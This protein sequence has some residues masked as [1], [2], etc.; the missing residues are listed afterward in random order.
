MPI[1]PR[2]NYL[3]TLEFRGPEW[4]PT[5]FNIAPAVWQKYREDME[6]VLLR[7]PLVFGEYDR[8][9]VAFDEF[10]ASYRENE[11]F[12]DEWG[13]VWHNVQE[14]MLGQV[15]GHP[16]ANWDALATY[17]LPDPLVNDNTMFGERNWE[18]I[19]AQVAAQKQRGEPTEGFAGCLFDRLFYL[20][21]FE[22]LMVDIATDAPQLRELTDILTHYELKMVGKWLELGVDVIHF[23][24]D[25][26]GQQA[27]MISPAKFRQHIKPMFK[28][29][30]QTCRAGG[31]HVY[32]S[33]D[34][35]LLEIVDDL[36]ECGV[37]VHDPQLR[38]NTLE[39][40][41]K[42]YKGKMCVKLDLD[43]QMFPFCTPEEIR[44]QVKEA[45]TRLG[46]PH[47]GLML[48]ACISPDV[49][50]QNIAA[51]AEAMEEFR[52]YWSNDESKKGDDS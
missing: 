12:T 44:E 33:S 41:V 35:H 48:W 2:E 28:Q 45:V 42:A 50:L 51:L 13:C 22:N 15:V 43:R 8:G 46:S 17:E 5:S 6:G 19:Q 10:A 47:G 20:R 7:H 32:M 27:L 1:S 37:S 31:A 24:T 38:A 40:I 26:G 11:Y 3:R 30:F 25:I 49:P 52:L 4:I 34:G 9:S 39:G 29:I 16:L 14:G 21:G 36:I 18:Q 23:H